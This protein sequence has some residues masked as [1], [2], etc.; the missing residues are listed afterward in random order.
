MR[1][2]ATGEGGPG[3]LGSEGTAGAG[4]SGKRRSRPS[5]EPGLPAG[6]A[7]SG[8]LCPLL[9]CSL[10]PGGLAGCGDRA[11]DHYIQAER[12]GEDLASYTAVNDATAWDLQRDR[13]QQFTGKN[14]TRSTSGGLVPPLRLSVNGRQ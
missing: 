7:R 12:M 11:D 1:F 14:V 4:F 6:A 13:V 5:P 9:E 2:R 3:W 10:L 8:S